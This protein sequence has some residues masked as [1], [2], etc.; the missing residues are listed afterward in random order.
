MDSINSFASTKVFQ[1]SV[2]LIHENAV[3]LLL[4]WQNGRI[5]IQ[6]SNVLSLFHVQGE[7]MHTKEEGT[8]EKEE[9]SRSL[10]A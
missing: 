7:D 4:W 5:V 1:C 6:N 2:F 3:V 9:S 8:K 10:A